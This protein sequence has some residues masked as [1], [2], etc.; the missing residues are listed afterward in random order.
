MIKGNF[1][2]ITGLKHRNGLQ[3]F[4]QKR[5][6]VKTFIQK[7]NNVQFVHKNNSN[8]FFSVVKLKLTA[9]IFGSVI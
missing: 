4:F 2:S 6:A 5:T 9:L 7:I 3:Y 1:T 8:Y